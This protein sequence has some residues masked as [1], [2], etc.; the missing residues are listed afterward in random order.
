M[1]RIAS[2]FL[3]LFAISV[4]TFGQETNF[5]VQVG[6]FLDAKKTDFDNIS[7]LGFVFAKP[8]ENNLSTIYIGNFAE[9]QGA[10]DALKTVIEK[11]YSNAS[12][13]ALTTDKR[14]PVFAVQI[15]TRR[16]G[17]TLDWASFLAVNDDLH[18]I[19]DEKQ[20]KIIAGAYSNIDEAKSQLEKA[21]ELGFDDAFV[22]K[23]DEGTLHEV[24]SFELGAVKRPLIPLNFSSGEPTLENQPSGYNQSATARGVRI[25]NIAST[26]DIPTIRTKVKRNSV[27]NLQK[28]LKA[29][30]TYQG[31][32][33]GYYGPNTSNGFKELASNHRVYEK[34]VAIAQMK[35]G[36][37]AGSGA[38]SLQQMLNTLNES[39]LPFSELEAYNAPIA[40]AYRAYLL[41]QNRGPSQ[42][43]NTLMNA[44]IKGAYG[45]R[46]S[47][48]ITPV[49]PS[50][51]Y[52]YNDLNQ[53]VLHLL[54]IHSAPE[55]SLMAPCWLFDT[56]PTETAQAT[57]T[58]NNYPG[59]RFD[60]EQCNQF[61]E[62]T[63]IKTLEAIATDLNSDLMIK[64]SRIQSDA[65]ARNN[66]YLAKQPLSS[67]EQKALED[68]DK[69]LWVALDSWATRDP[70]HQYTVEAMKLAYYE[71]FILL[72]DHFM[73]KGFDA[74]EARGLA[75]ATLHTVIGYHLERFV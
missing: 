51:T 15:A 73:N 49:D 23:V 8:D 57:N 68:W 46:R 4:C 33:D 64:Q 44:A 67:A 35:A 1:K 56:H 75:L 55:G 69:K 21:K 2:V 16:T 34:Y 37:S 48:A 65:N 7:N 9:R 31:S 74:K 43:V 53:L 29:K 20:V 71:S 54:Y 39:K 14:A 24:G 6:T 60:K 13:I 26:L 72:E 38:S 40:N 59:V 17:Q 11:G 63:P 61:V 52:A 22:K 32:L 70:L 42:E 12:L 58:L 25:L 3:L 18:L 36:S 27:L 28:V 47:G 66:L 5:A 50:A 41:F 10:Q 45:T 62:W 19:I 30:G